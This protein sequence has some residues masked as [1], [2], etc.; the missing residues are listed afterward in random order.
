MAADA[1]AAGG[2]EVTGLRA[3]ADAELGEGAGER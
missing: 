3:R 2:H 1:H